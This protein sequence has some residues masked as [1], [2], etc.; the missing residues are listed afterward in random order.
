V[1]YAAGVVTT[2]W[3]AISGQAPRAPLE[4]VRMAKKK[5]FVRHEKAARELGYAPEGVDEALRRAVEW[6]R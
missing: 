6:F 4:A 2:A 3:A 5:M 1:A